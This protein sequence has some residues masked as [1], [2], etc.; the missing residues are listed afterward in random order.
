[1]PTLLWREVLS[2]P[3]S[4][5]CCRVFCGLG[6]SFLAKKEEMWVFFN[7]VPVTF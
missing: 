5:S 3:C 6:D 1:M 7:A 2:R 4:D